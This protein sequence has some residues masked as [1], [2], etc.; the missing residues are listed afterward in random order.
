MS[1]TLTIQ[2]FGSSV[3]IGAFVAAEA[4]AAL[5]DSYPSSAFVWY[6]NLDVFPLFEAARA[7][8]SPLHVLFGPSALA[9]GT[10]LLALALLLRLLRL[11]FGVALI[12]NVSFACALALAYGGLHG[13]GVP[14]AAALRLSIG[15]QGS[16][17]AVTALMLASSFTAFAVSH[18]SFVRRIL[19]DRR[20]GGPGAGGP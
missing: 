5:L 19:A 17:L 18:V 2:T 10:A 16:D 14:R 12:A 15:G 4:A 6:L 11:R 13:G 3:V 9:G 20:A 1:R 8:G 7:Q